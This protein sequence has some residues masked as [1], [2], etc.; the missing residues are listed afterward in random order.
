MSAC[1]GYQAITTAAKQA[2]GVPSLIKNIEDAA[3]D[4]ASTRQRLQGAAFVVAVFAVG[5]GAKYA[6][7]RRALRREAAASAK[8]ELRR[9]VSDP[10]GPAVAPG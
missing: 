10:D 7:E 3:V 5:T 6:R 1:D 8:D 4:G 9:I 2:G